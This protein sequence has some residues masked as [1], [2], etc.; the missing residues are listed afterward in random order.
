[1][2]CFERLKIPVFSTSLMRAEKAGMLHRAT[3]FLL[4]VLQADTSKAG[5]RQWKK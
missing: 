5:H 2:R 3:D 1:L 4:D